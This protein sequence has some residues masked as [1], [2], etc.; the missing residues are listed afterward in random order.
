MNYKTM[1]HTHVLLASACVAI[2][3]SCGNK[4]HP[5]ASPADI[6]PTKHE[7]PVNTTG[8]KKAQTDM[9]PKAAIAVL[10]EYFSDLTVRKVKNVGIAT[11]RYEVKFTNGDEMEFDADGCVTEVN[12]KGRSVPD[13]LVPQ[14][15][16]DYVAEHYPDTFINDI[17]F[18]ERKVEIKLDGDIEIV[19][20]GKDYRL[21]SVD[22]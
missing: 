20:D 5:G 18:G 3:S 13:G 19:F 21:L 14:P 2:L 22:Y 9:L 16:R 1:K 4:Q 6:D 7:Q 11:N 10:N 12:T 17:E 8:K 15:I